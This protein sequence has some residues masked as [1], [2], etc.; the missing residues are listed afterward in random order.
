M[1][2]TSDAGSVTMKKSLDDRL[3]AI[4]AASKQVDIAPLPKL[5]RDRAAERTPTY[6]F[7][8][9]HTPSGVVKAIVKDLNATG[10]RLLLESMDRLPKEVAIVI[11]DIG[12][13]KVAEVVWQREQEFG[14]K[15]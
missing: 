10:A 15:F 14:L 7:A 4:S 6:K 11:S 8:Q 2:K 5:E 9:I 1:F 12:L 3:K 13:R